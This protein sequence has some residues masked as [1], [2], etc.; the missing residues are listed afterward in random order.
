MSSEPRSDVQHLILSPFFFIHF[1]WIVGLLLL[2]AVAVLDIV[3]K[4]VYC[5]CTFGVNYMTHERLPAYQWVL[6]CRH[7]HWGLGAQI[8][9]F[10][11]VW[12]TRNWNFYIWSWDSLIHW[13]ETW[14]TR[15]W[16]V[17]CSWKEV[18]NPCQYSGYD[19]P[20]TNHWSSEFSSSPKVCGWLQRFFDGEIN[21]QRKGRF[22]I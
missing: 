12:Q 8:N 17:Q 5:G 16:T 22:K 4:A 19:T 2:S 20:G 14:L 7:N 15:N 6:I 11:Q 9:F 21:G 13:A 18:G 1:S 3:L 10:S